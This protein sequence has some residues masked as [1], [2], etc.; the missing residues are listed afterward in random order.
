MNWPYVAPRSLATIAKMVRARREWWAAKKQF[1]AA[2]G[3]R[4]QNAHSGV[5]ATGCG[6]APL[7]SRAVEDWN[8]SGTLRDA[9]AD[10]ARPASLSAA[11]LS[12][13]APARNHKR[14]G[15]RGG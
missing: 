6:A 4:E 14:N 10:A 3:R 8:A 15:V 1:G 13:S 12:A 2:S 7:F 5:G 9:A 11:S